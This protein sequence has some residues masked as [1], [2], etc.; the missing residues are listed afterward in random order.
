MRIIVIGGTGLV[1]SQVVEILRRQGHAAVAAS[2]SSG[3]DATTG[4]G[5]AEALT[6]AEVVV[7]LT[8]PPVF[9]PD[10]V[11][12]FFTASG[13][14]LAAAEKAA[15]V[16]HHVALSIVGVDRPASHGFYIVGKVA[17]ERLIRE[18][19]VP[20]TIV[21]ATQFFEFLQGIADA[22]TSGGE[23]RVTS[24]TL[25][26]VAAAEVAA[27]VA[28]V[29][30]SAPANGVVEIAGPDRI[31]L[32]D[33]VERRLAALG[34]PR[35]V[36]ADDDAPYFGAVIDDDTLVPRDETY[37]HAATTFPAWLASQEQA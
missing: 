17:Q 35:K 1:G 28:E 25:Q 2:P 10:G 15:G 8:N 32:A 31:P 5:L 26:P 12:D 33:A 27:Y 23:V 4:A 36:I 13:E 37:R 21:R 24:K 3:V 7:D 18:S 6:G 16:G 22:S 29:A 9:T 20:F 14:H 19:G 34:D 30:L 11:L